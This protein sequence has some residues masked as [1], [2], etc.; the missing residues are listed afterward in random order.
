MYQVEISNQVDQGQD[1]EVIVQQEQEAK[2]AKAA[3][4]Q[5]QVMAYQAAQQTQLQN[6]GAGPVADIEIMKIV[7]EHAGQFEVIFKQD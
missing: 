7:N 6:G 1:P 2:D 4:I 3:E 5:A